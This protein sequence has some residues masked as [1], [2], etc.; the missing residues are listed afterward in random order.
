MKKKQ[1]T[2]FAKIL[3]KVQHESDNVTQAISIELNALSIPTDKIN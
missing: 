3:N 2:K 1:L